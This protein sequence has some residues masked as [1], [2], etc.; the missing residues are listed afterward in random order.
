MPLQESRPKTKLR[1][2]LWDMGGPLI[3]EE[4]MTRQ[5]LEAIRDA[6]AAETGQELAPRKLKEA[7]QRAVESFAP[8]AFRC[9]LWHLCDGDTELYPRMK[10]AFGSRV[11]P[12]SHELRP[13]IR[14]LLFEL[15]GRIPMG[16]VANQ[17]RGLEERLERMGIRSCFQT[18]NGSDDLNLWKPDTRLF[19]R[20]LNALG[21]SGQETV[22]I[23]DRQDNDIAPAKLMGMKAILFKTGTHV[24]QPFRYPEEEPDW[25]VNSVEELREVLFALVE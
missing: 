15:I 4:A 1:A 14:E 13:G 3:D 22:M 8:F 17:G 24:N 25:V 20:A 9:A 6:Y 16:M 23:G 12:Y 19:E 2:I 18:V 10:K 21:V 11:G 7:M 5:W